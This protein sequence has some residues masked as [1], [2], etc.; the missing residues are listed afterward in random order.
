MKVLKPKKRKKKKPAFNIELAKIMFGNLGIT[1][2]EICNSGLFLSFAHRHKRRWYT[3]VETINRFD[4]II[5]ACVP[6]HVELE[7]DSK[8]TEDTFKRLR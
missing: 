1:R 5:L 6:C 8:L 2:C 7:K 3:G 4:Q